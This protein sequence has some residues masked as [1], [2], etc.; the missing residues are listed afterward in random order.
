MRRG[1]QL[2]D[3]LLE[4]LQHFH[5]EVRGEYEILF[6]SV[7]EKQ[8]PT[9]LMITCSDSRIVPAL[10]CQ[11]EPGD[12]FI[13]RNAGN[14]VPPYDDRGGGVAATIEYAIDALGVRHIVVCGHS[15]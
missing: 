12:L 1:K 7:A 14:I 10:M 9:A 13:C 2:M 15:N 8:Q 11:C 3:K 5:K 4:G 6:H